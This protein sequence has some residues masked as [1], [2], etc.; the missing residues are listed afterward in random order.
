MPSGD[1][2]GDELSCVPSNV[3]RVGVSS[4]TSNNQR[5]PPPAS[6]RCTTICFPSG[7][8][9]TPIQRPAALAG[10]IWPSRSS[11]ERGGGVPTPPSERPPSAS[12]ARERSALFL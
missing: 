5:S 4:P 11:Q 2:I 10:V 3:K 6:W 12:G 8:R 7:D 9:S 1:Q